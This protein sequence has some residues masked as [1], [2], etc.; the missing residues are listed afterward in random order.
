MALADTIAGWI[1]QQ[2]ESAGLG[3]AV[4]GLSGGIDSAVVSGLCAQAVGADKVLGIAMPC[5]SD[6]DDTKHAVLTA[7]TWG[8]DY[9]EID[10]SRIYDEF[11]A[12]LPKGNDL[13]EANIKP[14]LRMITLYQRANTL[15]RLVVGT[16][17]KSELM[18]GYYTKYGDGGVDILPIGSLLKVQVRK[19]ARE[20][21]VPEE[22]IARPPSAG[23]WAGQTDEAELGMTYEDL[24]QNTGGTRD[25]RYT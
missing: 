13:A 18:V 19:L 5:H 8:I 25:R 1:K 10:L 24:D 7:K 22:I 21:G 6:P 17:N 20:M 15:N 9:L 2:V 14:R 3:G 23:L 11:V 16:G 4:L 12:L